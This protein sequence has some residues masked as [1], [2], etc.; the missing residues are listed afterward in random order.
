MD[1]VLIGYFPKIVVSNP[2]WLT[3]APA[4]EEVCSVSECISTAPPNWID[5][6]RH[7][8]MWVYDTPDL[9]WA[10]IPDEDRLRY[11]LF[12]YRILPR[13]F[14]ESGETDIPLPQLNVIPL[15][16]G[17]ISLGFDAVS[18]SGEAGFECSP[19]SCNSLASAY[20][21]NR[22][23]L[24]NDIDTA[25]AMAQDFTVGKCEP[26]P[27]YVVEVLRQENNEQLDGARR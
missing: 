7:N 5:K 18:R 10:V 24:V 16:S 9:A 19:L 22:H 6:W 15:P 21:V 14:D 1:L 8:A 13:R 26:G 4:V 17:F 11:T 12:A 20:P 23:C 25:I 3:D 2:D 27:Y